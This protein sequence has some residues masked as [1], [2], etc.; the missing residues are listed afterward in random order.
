MIDILDAPEHV[1][2]LRFEGKLTG[3]DVGRYQGALDAKLTQQGKIGLC[4]D[5]TGL[6]DMNADAL[7][8]GTKADLDAL[9]HLSRFG[10]LAIVSDKEWPAA[11]IRFIDPMLPTLE[12]RAFG[13]DQA[14]AAMAWAAE[15]SRTAEGQAPAFRF[16]PTSRDDVLAFEINGAITSEAMPGVIEEVEAFLARHD[17]ARLLGRIRHF[18]GVD[19]SV[20]MQGGLVSMKLAAMEKVE[21]YAVVGAPGWMGKAVEAMNPVFPG[22]D[23]RAFAAESE[24]DAWAWL[25]A[26]PGDAA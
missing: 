19:P 7:I 2:A 9:A 26:K 14:D 1:I 20:F 18:G 3:E 8:K 12:M 22:I 10:R 6:S 23:M 21:R 25:G 17:K 4:V 5:I 16:I 15:P 11:A 13:P 24:A